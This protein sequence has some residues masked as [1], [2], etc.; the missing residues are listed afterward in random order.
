M[1][2][3]ETTKKRRPLTLLWI[4]LAVLLLAAGATAFFLVQRTYACVN[5]TL[6]KRD[7]QTIDL[8]GE[9]LTVERYTSY[10][11][12]M[13]DAVLLWSVPIAGATVDSTATE[14]ALPAFSDADVPLLA[15]LPALTRLDLHGCTQAAVLAAVRDAYPAL[16]LQ[17]AVSI[18]DTA[19]ECDAT[20]AALDGDLPT[21]EALSTA[22]SLLPH[23]TALDLSACTPDDAA[24]TALLDAFPTLSITWTAD[25]LGVSLSSAAETLDLSSVTP[26]D[27]AAL[28]AALDPLA[29]YLPNLTT[30]DL[31]DAALTAAEVQALTD[32]Y[33]NLTIACRLAFCGQ[34]LDTANTEVLTLSDAS[35]SDPS[36]GEIVA[37]LP[38]LTTLDVSTCTAMT[39][40]SLKALAARFPSL[41]LQFSID[42]MGVTL[43]QATTDFSLAGVTLADT[44]ALESV[45]ALLPAL[46]RVDLCG[47]GLSDET[48]MALNDAYAGKTRFIWEFSLGFWGKVRTDVVVYSTHSNK[49]PAQNRNRL[50][51][52]DCKCFSYCLDLQALDLGHQNLTDLSWIL[53]LKNLRILILADSRITD[54]SPLAALTNLQ[55]VELFMNDITDVSPL[56]GL[57]NLLDL[58]LCFNELT[59]VTPLYTLT[60]LERLWIRCYTLTSAQY[61]ALTESLPTCEVNSTASASTEDGWREHPR[62]QWIRKCFHDYVLYDMPTE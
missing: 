28:T 43:T 29:P 42:F 21:V 7:V 50:T 38:S 25:I 34:T 22:L 45:V 10:Q 27:V 5:G 49:E 53:P 35:L 18:G 20:H 9:S 52:E 36:L 59:D 17:Y 41:S 48:M 8:R 26:C 31:G 44:T 60:G 4:L 46:T 24:A 57:S 55:Y 6:Y 58:N 16:A 3:N 30:L 33:P 2:M 39:P 23:L 32:A 14:A 12:Q 61:K 37:L 19:I 62:Y 56:A 15:Y 47:C 11:A 13:P 40:A 1:Q 51:S 54:I